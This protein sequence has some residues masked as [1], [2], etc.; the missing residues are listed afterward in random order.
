MGEWKWDKKC[1]HLLV[2][3]L[4]P[5][6]RFGLKYAMQVLVLMM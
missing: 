3:A 1:W 5:N 2:L 6:D 4:N